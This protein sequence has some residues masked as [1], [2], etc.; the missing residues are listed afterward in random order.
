[1]HS[2]FLEEGAT[3]RT[4]NS[5]DSASASASEDDLLEDTDGIEIVNNGTD[6][7]LGKLLLDWSCN[8]SG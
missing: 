6:P 7:F 5:C 4:P 3:C 2:L 1:M 8:Y